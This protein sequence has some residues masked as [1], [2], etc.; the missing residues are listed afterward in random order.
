MIPAD[1]I[2]QA[3]DADIVA[4]AEALGAKLKRVSTSELADPCPRCGSGRD[5][6]AVNIRK[7]LWGCRVC[8]RGGS[9]AISLVV[10]VRGLGFRDA[11]AFLAGGEMEAAAKVPRPVT[12]AA[13]DDPARIRRALAV[14]DEAVYPR[15]TL[16][17]RY[18][19]RRALSLG[20]DLAGVV[21]RWHQHSCAMVALFRNIS[22]RQPQA[23]S[24]AFLDRDGRKL[25]RKFLGPVAGAAIMLDPA[26]KV[27][28]ELH[29]GE[30]VE[31]TMAARRLGLKPAW[32]L[33]SAGAIAAFP[34]LD[35]VGRLNLLGEND[36][37]GGNA[38]AVKACAARWG[39]AG[40][41]AILIEPI[42]GND[43]NDVL[44]SGIAP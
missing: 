41:E 4:T 35:R 29:V 42:G 1:A 5:R 21:L 44:A 9:D 40:R 19:N 31:T 43:L 18:L 28:G 37:N 27:L 25:G 39:A 26:E 15:G 32:A 38:R 22:T 23:I 36:A 6:F 3:R 11:V 20:D 8:G 33:G 24:R 34:V 17:E 13:D 7:R 30:G 10:H 12:P 16:A 2:A 14:W